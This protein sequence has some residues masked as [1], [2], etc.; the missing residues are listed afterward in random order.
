MEIN[1]KKDFSPEQL[2][3]LICE[4]YPSLD[5]VLRL[6]IYLEREQEN[7]DFVEKF[8]KYAN[9]LNETFLSKVS[10]SEEDSQ[11]WIKNTAPEDDLYWDKFL[12]ED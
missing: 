8:V 4:D 5:D 3:D 1:I 9:S 11:S 12:S 10:E 2:K 7:W 6:I